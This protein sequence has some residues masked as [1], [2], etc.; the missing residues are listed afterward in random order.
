MGGPGGNRTLSW[1]LKRQLLDHRAASPCLGDAALSNVE[2]TSAVARASERCGWEELNLQARRR[3]GYS[4]LGAP[5]PSIHM[6]YTIPDHAAAAARSC[7]GNGEGRLGVPGG[8]P[9]VANDERTVPRSNPP[10]ARLGR[11]GAC[12]RCWRRPAFAG[13]ALLTMAFDTRAH[14]GS[15]ERNRSQPL[16]FRSNAIDS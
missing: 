14:D 9:Y 16:K 15:S 7:S 8:P 6:R 4:R 13:I 11:T 5:V 1:L 12:A 2:R 3:A 10:A